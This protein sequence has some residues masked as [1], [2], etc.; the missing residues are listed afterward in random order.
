MKVSSLKEFA[1]THGRANQCSICRLPEVD[2]INSV[3]REKSVLYPT[4]VAWLRERGH[5]D[6]TVPKIKSHVYAGHHLSV[7]TSSEAK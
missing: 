6:I 3:V 5:D 4:I 2:E 1:K 7:G